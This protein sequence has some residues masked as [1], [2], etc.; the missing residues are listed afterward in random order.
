MT[1]LKTQMYLVKTLHLFNL[2]E[3]TCVHSLGIRPLL[4]QSTRH[5]VLSFN[6]KLL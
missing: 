4:V 6:V 5:Y 2:T 1:T 3:G